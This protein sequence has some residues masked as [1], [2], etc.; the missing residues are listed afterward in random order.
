MN[1]YSDLNDELANRLAS[2]LKELLE[3]ERRSVAGASEDRQLELLE[4]IE[5][6]ERELKDDELLDKLFERYIAA[7]PETERPKNRV[8][9]RRMFN[10]WEGGL[11]SELADWKNEVAN[12]E[13]QPIDKEAILDN[14]RN[15]VLHLLHREARTVGVL[16]EEDDAGKGPDNM[17]AAKFI[18]NGNGVPEGSIDEWC[19]LTALDLSAISGRKPRGMKLPGGQAVSKKTWAEILSTVAEWLVHRGLITQDLGPIHIGKAKRPLIDT[20]RITYNLNYS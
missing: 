18:S 10:D 12:L 17:G 9:E 16:P 4:K 19:Q 8:Q 5:A 14:A 7:L 2:L 3:Q 15:K 20:K 1:D 6:R 11:K 13:K